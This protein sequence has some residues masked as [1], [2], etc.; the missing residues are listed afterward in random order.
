[1]AVPGALVSGLLTARLAPA[2]PAE[3]AL[4]VAWLILAQAG[5]FL[6]AIDIAAYRLPT[7]VVTV[8]AGMITAAIATAT[9]LEHSS[10][11][12]VHAGLGALTVGGVYLL[13]F[14]LVPSGIGAGDV[15]LAAVTGLTLGSSNWRAV[16]LGLALPYLLCLPFAVAMVLR[17]NGPHTAQIPFGPFLIG[18]SLVAAV[19]SR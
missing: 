2:S 16:T 9:L 12:L 4:L 17:R 11:T 10:E 14:V 18:G 7:R 5:V 8:I 1:M 6:S 13:L 3:W 15:R 19:T